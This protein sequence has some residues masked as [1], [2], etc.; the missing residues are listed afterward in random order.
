ML[1]QTVQVLMFSAIILLLSSSAILTGAQPNMVLTPAGPSQPDQPSCN[2]VVNELSPCLPYVRGREDK[3]S[4]SCCDGAK[5]LNDE[6]KSKQ[7]KQAACECIKKV[8]NT[9][10]DVDTSR[11][12][13]LPKECGISFNL[14]PIDR[15]FDCTT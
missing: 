2:K 3:P 10:P 7:D 1:R 4:K 13:S 8:L 9:L 5:Q 12:S 11:I 14:P 15:N 6:A